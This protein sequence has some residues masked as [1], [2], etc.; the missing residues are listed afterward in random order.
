MRS[1]SHAAASP[2]QHLLSRLRDFAKMVWH[3]QS[4]S[5]GDRT[6][7]R[8]ALTTGSPSYADRIVR[9]PPE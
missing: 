7:H 2:A 8:V 1:P 9:G 3:E 6:M 4:E 5:V